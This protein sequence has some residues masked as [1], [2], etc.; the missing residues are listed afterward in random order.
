[1][2]TMVRD[3]KEEL[4]LLKKDPGEIAEVSKMMS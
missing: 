4:D 3:L 1:M 2:N